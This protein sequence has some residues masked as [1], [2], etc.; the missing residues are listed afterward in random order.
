[1]VSTEVSL[2]G[3]EDSDKPE[4]FAPAVDRRAARLAR[5]RSAEK[6]VKVEKK[7]AETAQ[8]KR[9]EK[10]KRVEDERDAAFLRSEMKK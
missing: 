4:G 8:R 9:K 1:M 7:R 3:S 6:K 2:L 10:V 5:M